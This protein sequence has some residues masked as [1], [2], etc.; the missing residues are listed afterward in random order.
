LG[1]HKTLVSPPECCQSL[2]CDQSP[3]YLLSFCSPAPFEVFPEP[4]WSFCFRFF[5]AGHECPLI[6]CTITSLTNLSFHYNCLSRPCW[7]GQWLMGPPNR[8]HFL[9][10]LWF[11]LRCSLHMREP[12]FPL[13]GA[14][15]SRASPPPPSPYFLILCFSYCPFI[16]WEGNA[17]L[18]L[19]P[20]A[21]LKRSFPMT[22]FPGHS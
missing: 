22:H 10:S 1:P 14:K 15:T 12:A 13:S 19:I 7:F 20:P 11:F 9:F 21:N 6:F 16:S 17:V 5:V 8:Q 18:S 2:F 4:A 3:S